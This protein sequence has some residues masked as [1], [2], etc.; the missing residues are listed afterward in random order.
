MVQ[1]TSPGFVEGVPQ[2]CATP[3]TTSLLEDFLR[4]RRTCGLPIDVKDG[5][6]AYGRRELLQ[7]GLPTCGPVV[8]FTAVCQSALGKRDARQ[9]GAAPVNR[10]FPKLSQRDADRNAAG[11]HA[12]NRMPL[13]GI[14]ATEWSVV[15]LLHV[16]QRRTPLQAAA[17][18]FAFLTLTSSSVTHRF[19]CGHFLRGV[20]SA[21][22]GQSGTPGS[23]ADNVA[24]SPAATR[25]RVLAKRAA[26]GYDGRQSRQGRHMG[27]VVWPTVAPPIRFG[28][29]PCGGSTARITFGGATG[30][31][32]LVGLRTEPLRNNSRFSAPIRQTRELRIHIHG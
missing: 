27:V 3:Q 16:D 15:G 29:W 20:W 9:I 32:D 5:H 19:L 14:G 28:V 25:R 13:M 6:R 11:D 30:R 26:L 23:H 31:A 24:D 1:Q 21:R 7:Q 22:H 18:S 17:A 8:K 12:D 2:D 4:C 10:R